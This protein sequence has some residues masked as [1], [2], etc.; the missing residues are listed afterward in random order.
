MLVCGWHAAASGGFV[1]DIVVIERP[2][3]HEF[4]RNT[5]H[6][7]TNIGWACDIVAGGRRR[8]SKTGADAFTA[9]LGQMGGGFGQHLEIGSHRVGK[10]VLDPG[11][12]SF[13]CGQDT[14]RVARRHGKND[15]SIWAGDRGRSDVTT[16][17][18]GFG[19]GVYISGMFAVV[20]RLHRWHVV[21]N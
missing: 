15:T 17:T 21:L 13:E 9:G 6:E 5:T 19:C 10:K 3:V 8:N 2:Q 20:P 12:V 16:T 7:H 18:T 11:E 1:H 14:E 4:N